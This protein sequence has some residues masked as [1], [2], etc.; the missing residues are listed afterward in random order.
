MTYLLRLVACLFLCVSLNSFGA[1]IKISYSGQID[2]V[3]PELSQGSVGLGQ[4]FNG[5]F[6]FNTEI[7]DDSVY[8]YF[9]NEGLVTL[10]ES[11]HQ[12]AVLE[13][14]I[15]FESNV[16]TFDTGQVYMY[17]EISQGITRI[18]WTGQNPIIGDSINGNILNSI[19]LAGINLPNLISI[20]NPPNTNS[21][22]SFDINSYSPILY[23]WY[24]PTGNFFNTGSIDFIEA[25]EVPLPAGIY[26]FLSGLVGLG[27][28][29]R[30]K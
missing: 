15:N 28:I 10:R 1:I 29:K 5:H 11:H 22:S 16:F 2:T 23:L 9:S 27:L 21:L 24:N 7:S 3:S 30:R 12:G 19:T 14:I 17:N 13:A 6:I 18:G 25:S 20:D 8:E 26:L 4:S